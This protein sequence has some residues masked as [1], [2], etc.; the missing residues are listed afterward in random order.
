[1]RNNA[2]LQIMDALKF[3][4]E[5]FGPEQ[6][7]EILCGDKI[8]RSEGRRAE[9]V[10]STR[11]FLDV[12]TTELRFTVTCEEGKSAGARK[13][14]QDLFANPDYPKVLRNRYR[15]LNRREIKFWKMDCHFRRSGGGQKDNDFI[16]EFTVS[17]GDEV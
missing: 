16:I 9:D 3:V 1:M 5:V 2:Y 12:S 6:A 15:E 4:D 17:Y 14:I 10:M 8:V 13:E 11:T 7:V